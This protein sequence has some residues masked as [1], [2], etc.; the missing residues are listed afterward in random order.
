MCCLLP[1]PCFE[2]NKELWEELVYVKWLLRRTPKAALSPKYADYLQITG[3][4]RIR[5]SL[6]LYSCIQCVYSSVNGNDGPFYHI[7]QRNEDVVILEAIRRQVLR[8]GFPHWILDQV[9]PQAVEY[10]RSNGIRDVL[11][12][13]LNNICST[14]LMAGGIKYN[15]CVRDKDGNVLITIKGQL[16]N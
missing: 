16:S 5:H 9:C 6:S 14:P 4:A 8:M 7:L 12:E 10:T 2:Q 15:A 1:S 13:L 11:R 3:M